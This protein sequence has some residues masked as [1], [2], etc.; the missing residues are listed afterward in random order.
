MHFL[1]TAETS[2]EDVELYFPVCGRSYLPVDRIFGRAEKMLRKKLTTLTLEEYQE[3]YK[4]IDPVNVLGEDWN[5]VDTKS[6]NKL[7]KDFPCISDLKRLS[8]KVEITPRGQKRVLVKENTNFHYISDS[9]EEY[10]Y[11]VKKGISYSHLQ[12]VQ[13]DTL[14]LS[15]F[16]SQEKKNDLKVMFGDWKNL[17]DR[18]LEWYKKILFD[19]P[20]ANIEEQEV[21]CDCVEPEPFTI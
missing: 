12:R 8:L 9:P 10:S 18:G 7:Y 2:V 4:R 11:L 15:H 6:L 20:S 3:V 13:P 17:G 16:I 5:I 14:P 21:I 1:I 19:E